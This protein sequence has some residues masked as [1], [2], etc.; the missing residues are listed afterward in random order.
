MLPV[1]RTHIFLFLFLYS[2][3][4]IFSQSNSDEFKTPGTI[5]PTEKTIYYPLGL[6]TIPIKIQQYGDNTDLVF[7]NLHDDEFTSVDA[8]REIL[9]RKGGLLIKFENDLKRNIRFQTGPYFY[10]VDPNRIFAKEGISK[11]LL[12]L[13]RSSPK[14]IQLAEKFGKRI[15]DLI[16]KNAKCIIALHNN[17]PDRFTAL[18]YAPGNSREKEAKKT[19]INPS[20]DPDDFFLTTDPVLYSALSA[21]GYNSILQDNVNCTEDGSLSV[22]YKKGNI[23][24][25]NCETEHGKKEKYYAMLLSLVEILEKISP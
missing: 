12:E 15:L 1:M 4:S 22:Y 18:W 20:E 16:P 5:I 2:S 11:S 23:P 21:K 13:G 14:A 17:S 6:R 25:V 7:I 19:F 3:Q 10:S 8:A 24:Y 9:T